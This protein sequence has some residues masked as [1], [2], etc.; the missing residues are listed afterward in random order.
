MIADAVGGS[1]SHL[2]VPRQVDLQCFAVV[3]E[4]ERSHGEENVL[5]VHRLALLLLAFLRCCLRY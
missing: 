5:A 2:S 3:L 1:K 4:A